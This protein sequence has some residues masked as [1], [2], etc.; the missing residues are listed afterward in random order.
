MTGS[1]LVQSNMEIFSTRYQ[2]IKDD[3][4]PL[5]IIDTIL[6]SAMIKFETVDASEIGVPLV[7][8]GIFSRD[9]STRG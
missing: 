7:G 9:V 3:S 8:E 1:F 6:P 2:I 5:H 4:V